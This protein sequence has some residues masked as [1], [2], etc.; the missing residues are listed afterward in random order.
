MKTPEQIRDLAKEFVENINDGK[1]DNW[2]P[3]D[4]DNRMTF[5]GAFEEGYAKAVFDAL[6]EK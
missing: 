2:T 5:I 6:S 4:F 1:I 3:L